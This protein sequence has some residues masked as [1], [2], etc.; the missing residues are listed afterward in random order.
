MVIVD[1][2]LAS[3]WGHRTDYRCVKRVTT[4]PQKASFL[5]G[6]NHRDCGFRPAPGRTATLGGPRFQTFP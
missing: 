4:K 6:R 3:S 1:V 5:T 2:V